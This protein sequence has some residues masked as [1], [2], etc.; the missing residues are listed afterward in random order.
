MSS[1]RPWI[2]FYVSDYRNDIRVQTLSFEDKGLYTDM[3][4]L[5]WENGG[6]LPG[7][8]PTLAKIFKLSE[9][10]FAKKFQKISF[11]FQQEEINGEFFLTQKRLKSEYE[12]SR[13]ISD[14]RR[15][16][17][18]SRVD[19]KEPV[20]GTNVDTNGVTKPVQTDSFVADLNPY[21]HSHSHSHIKDIKTL[22]PVEDPGEI[23]TLRSETPEKPKKPQEPLEEWFEKFYA[24]YP[25]RED[26]K[27]TRKAFMA[28]FS[29][30]PPS[31]HREIMENLIL[32]LTAYVD[33]RKRAMEANP[34]AAQYT[35]Y[36]ATWLNAHDFT[37][38]PPDDEILMEDY[39]EPVGT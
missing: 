20:S 7:D 23:L 28:I 34:E 24:H 12:K 8:L 21:S 36:P 13:S 22:S 17:V 31:K 4:F 5:M 19:R 35:K 39:W 30:S 26:R 9:K 16:A 3:L 2:P 14:K 6:V 1:S 32:R 18:D 11:F 38:P 25:R 33:E 15:R 10:K 29:K 27:R 37:I